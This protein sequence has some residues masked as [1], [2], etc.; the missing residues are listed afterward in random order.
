MELFSHFRAG[1]C[2]EKPQASVPAGLSVYAV[3]D[4]HGRSDLLDSLARVI[5]RAAA[6]TS[7]QVLTV[8]L[9]DYLDR[10]IKSADVIERLATRD[11]PTP[12][13]ALRGNHEATFLN[14]LDDPQILAEWRHWGALETLVSYGVD[15]REVRL[16][17]GFETAQAELKSVLP[18]HHLKFL[19]ETKL[20][21]SIGDYF[22]CHAGARPHVPLDAQ[23]ERDL[24]WIRDEF[25]THAD[26]F[27]QIVVHGHTPVQE[28]ELLPHRINVDTGAYVSGTLT[29]VELSGSE[30][31]LLTSQSRRD[32][33]PQQMQGVSIG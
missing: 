10:G 33:R 9:G 30:R 13:I 4:I 19:Q 22:F 32:D 14:F 18:T 28:A 21:C 1:R 5:E 20:S 2:P 16:G 25:L 17:R 27:E 7:G 3:G 6:E 23:S 8:F 29:C 26:G 15:V 24:L 11:F 12:F 31:R